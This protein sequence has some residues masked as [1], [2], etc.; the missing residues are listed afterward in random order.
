MIG[1]LRIRWGDVFRAI[2][3]GVLTKLM[4]MAIAIIPFI[5]WFFTRH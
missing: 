4:A 1:P 5:Y 2:L 3:P